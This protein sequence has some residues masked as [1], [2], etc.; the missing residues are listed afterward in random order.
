M[1]L[2]AERVGD[3]FA[4]AGLAHT[5]RAHEAQDGALQIAFKL[6]NGQVLDTATL[7]LLKA[8]MIPVKV[9]SM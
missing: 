2:P 4:D 6:V 7:D 3:R 5:G 1:K 8:I 9:F